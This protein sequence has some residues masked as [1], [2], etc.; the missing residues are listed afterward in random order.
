MYSFNIGFFCAILLHAFPFCS[1]FL[2][3]AGNSRQ[4]MRASMSIMGSASSPKHG[5]GVSIGGG[6]G[7]GGMFEL[8]Y[9]IPA[10]SLL[11]R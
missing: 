3:Y 1:Y 5:I 8:P 9:L 10:D 4:S 2:P 7:G 11:L 6:G